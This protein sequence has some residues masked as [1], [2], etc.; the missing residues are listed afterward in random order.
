MYSFPPLTNPR[1]A[2]MAGNFFSCIGVFI[3]RKIFV[4]YRFDT[5]AE[6]QGMED[7]E[8]WIRILAEYKPGRL[9]KVNNG[10]LHHK[11]RSMTKYDLESFTSRGEYII[12]KIRKDPALNSCYGPYLS[13]F[14]SHCR[15]LT[16]S[17]A[18]S[19]GLFREARSYWLK[20]FFMRPAIVFHLGNLRIIQKALFHLEHKHGI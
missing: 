3:S 19:N 10:I 17:R 1:K 7:W 16:A 15:L 12:S 18:N 2:I 6:L 13:V 4:K 20:G 9:E 5:S 11:G 14:R 8:F